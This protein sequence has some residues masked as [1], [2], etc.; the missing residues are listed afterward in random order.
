MLIRVISAP[1]RCPIGHPTRSRGIVTGLS[2]CCNPTRLRAYPNLPSVAQV[3]SCKKYPVSIDVGSA[4]LPRRPLLRPLWIFS[5][6]RKGVE[7]WLLMRRVR[8]AIKVPS[9]DFI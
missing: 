3:V 5:V 1:S 8:T 7:P 9:T 2:E 4:V 6:L